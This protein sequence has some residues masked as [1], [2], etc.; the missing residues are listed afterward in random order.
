MKISNETFV[1]TARCQGQQIQK[2]HENSIILTASMA[3]IFSIFAN[4]LSLHREVKS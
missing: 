4:E 1:N 2:T 3:C